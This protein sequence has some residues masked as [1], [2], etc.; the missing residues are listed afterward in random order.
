MNIV[1]WDVLSIELPLPAPNLQKA[2]DFHG[3]VCVTSALTD[4]PFRS[5]IA[6]QEGGM[7][8]LW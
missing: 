7:E 3:K 6:M 2:S 5:L 8:M 4:L 1:R